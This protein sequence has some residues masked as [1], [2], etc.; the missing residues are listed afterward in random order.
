MRYTLV[1]LGLPPLATSRTRSINSPL[2]ATGTASGVLDSSF[3]T[4]SKLEIWSPFTNDSAESKGSVVLESRFHRLAWGHAAGLRSR[5][6]IAAGMENAE[7]DIWDPVKILA[8][9]GREKALV[10]KMKNH[11]GP[12]KG[13]DFNPV[14]N[15]LLASGASKG[16][17]FIWDLNNP[18]KPL[19]PPP[20]VH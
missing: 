20:H 18:I 10:S 1:S 5:G 13:L 7:L 9:E 19:L 14:K 15:N 12:V 3:S 2:L 11:N 16:E 17:V 4:D 6:V 8:G